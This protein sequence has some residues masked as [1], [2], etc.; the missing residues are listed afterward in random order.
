MTI[1][2]TGTLAAVC[3]AVLNGAHIVRV[4]EV[5]SARAAVKI[6]DAILDV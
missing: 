2:E 4:H 6:I 3:A 5:A 1:V